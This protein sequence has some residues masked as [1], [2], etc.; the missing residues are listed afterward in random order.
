MIRLFKEED[1][2]QI[3]KILSDT[4]FKDCVLKEDKKAN[5]L[6][7]IKE[8]I[9]IGLINLYKDSIDKY[10]EL[11]EVWI[12]DDLIVLE[13]FRSLGIGRELMYEMFKHIAKVKEDLGITK[14]YGEVL[15][16]GIDKKAM[17]LGLVED[18][19]FEFIKRVDDAWRDKP[20]GK[21]CSI[22]NGDCH[23]SSILYS[24]DV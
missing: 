12:I 11:K 18:Y 15:E 21:L 1:L 9:V 10:P 6:V 13:E 4:W 16:R 14:V 24:L 22:C 19:N 2:E 3:N 7:Y 8:G 20:S 17:S 23:C 5:T